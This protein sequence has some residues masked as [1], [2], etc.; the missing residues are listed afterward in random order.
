MEIKRSVDVW[1]LVSACIFN[2][3]RHVCGFRLPFK[4][5]VDTCFSLVWVSVSDFEQT[6]DFDDCDWSSL[7]TFDSPAD[8][9]SC[10]VFAHLEEYRF[11]WGSAHVS[12]SPVRSSLAFQV[13]QS[14][15]AFVFRFFFIFIHDDMRSTT[16]VLKYVT[17]SFDRAPGL[18]SRRRSVMPGILISGNATPM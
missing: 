13:L 1:D 4:S 8:R 17:C 11:V 2:G 14:L 10:H 18:A 5:N 3:V 12:A 6:I 16:S 9:L 7:Q 15:L